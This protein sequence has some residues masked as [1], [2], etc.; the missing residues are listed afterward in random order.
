M[1]FPEHYKPA[2]SA[3]ASDRV[4]QSSS[5]EFYSGVVTVIQERKEQSWKQ[6]DCLGNNPCVQYTSA[7]SWA[8]PRCEHPAAPVC[9]TR[10]TEILCHRQ[11][12]LCDGRRKRLELG[13]LL[14]PPTRRPSR[15]P[16]RPR[17]L[18]TPSPCA[19]RFKRIDP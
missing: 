10:L 3:R 6:C 7:T 4:L 17:L 8:I 1:S 14:L 12:Q 11:H 15:Q 5:V 16:E 2:S 19:E 9:G 18:L 13:R